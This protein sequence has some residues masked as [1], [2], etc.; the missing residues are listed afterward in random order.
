MKSNFLRTLKIDTV[1]SVNSFIYSLRKLPILK[2]LFTNDIYSSKVLKKIVG[3]IGI[4]F[5]LGRMFL[6]KFVYFFALY[7][8]SLKCYK[9]VDRGFIHLF[10]S[11]TILGMFINNKLLTTSKKKYFSL[12]LFDM[13]GGDFLKSSLWWNSIQSLIFNCL[14]FLVF[15]GTMHYSLLIVLLLLILI[16]FGRFIGESLNIMFYRKYHYVWYVNTVLYIIVLGCGLGLCLLPFLNIYVSFE[17]ILGVTVVFVLLGIISLKHLYSIDDY[18]TIYKRLNQI[19]ETMNSKNQND[20]FR[21]NMVSV[22][23]KDKEISLKKLKGKNGY[24]LFNTIF[25]ERHREILMRSAKNYSI[26]LIIVYIV[27]FY[28]VCTD[29]HYKTSI[30]AVFSNHLAW[31]ILIMYFVNRG[32][33][34]TQAMFFNCDHA[35]LR[36][37]FYRAPSTLLGL[38]QKRLKTMIKVNLIPALVIGIGNSLLFYYLQFDWLIIITSFLFIVLLSIFYSTHYLVI[39]YLLQPYNKK[40]EMRKISYSIVTILTYFIAYILTHLLIN[41]VLLSMVGVLCTIVYIG[42]S[43][44]LVYRFAPR[45]FHL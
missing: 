4:I 33:I 23:D 8:I 41:S 16:C 7:Y 35:M 19:S 38:F 43:L 45:T 32:S 2:D 40:M 29:I 42:L 11:L 39:Y 15:L 20:Y 10:F 6:F 17:I 3:I 44:L 25:F 21:Q 12:L 5:S 31:F 22:R 24:E 26:V 1:Y 27:L 14:C 13:D 28:L 18:K 34:V 9:D 36:Y 30:V 37:N